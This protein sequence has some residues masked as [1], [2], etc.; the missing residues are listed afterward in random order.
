MLPILLAAGAISLASTAALTAVILTRKSLKKK[1]E[2]DRKKSDITHL[3]EKEKVKKYHECSIS[4]LIDIEDT[5]KSL[6]KEGIKDVKN[7]LDKA[8]HLS[9]SLRQAKGNIKLKISMIKSRYTVLVES[10]S[11]QELNDSTYKIIDLSALSGPQKEMAQLAIQAENLHIKEFSKISATIDRLILALELDKDAITTTAESL[12]RTNIDSKIAFENTYAEVLKYIITTYGPSTDAQA[13]DDRE[14][15]GSE[16][17]GSRSEIEL[18][19]LGVISSSHS[20]G[21]RE[22]NRVFSRSERLLDLAVKAEKTLPK[23]NNKEIE[24]PDTP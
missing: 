20:E 22:E 24:G 1:F 11:V 2:N 16:P 12:E 10:G 21:N 15:T 7:F 4:H 8:D 3:R 9:Y 17:D 5:R 23:E 13:G 18:G 6:D 14:P 19:E